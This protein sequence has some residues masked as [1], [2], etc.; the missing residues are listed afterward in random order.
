MAREVKIN[1]FK[2]FSKFIPSIM[3]KDERTNY[4][5]RRIVFC[6]KK[7]FYLKKTIFLFKVLVK[8]CE[9]V[10]NFMATLDSGLR[11]KNNVI[12]KE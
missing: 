6:E 12:N 9:V 8:I 10:N 3:S 4:L 1:K 7:I 2:Y 5:S 11:E